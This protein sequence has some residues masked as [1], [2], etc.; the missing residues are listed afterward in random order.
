MK[1]HI[2]YRSYLKDR[3]VGTL[4]PFST[5][6][7]PWRDNRPNVSCIL[8]D[9][10]TCHRDRNGRYKYYRIDDV[11]G[12]TDIEFHGGIVVTHSAGCILIGEGFTPEFNLWR[13]DD[14]LSNFVEYMGEESF[15]LDIRVYQPCTKL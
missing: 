10:Y 4:G 8:P 9:V 14:T 1:T 3:T 2:L 7:R 12:R 15:N 6:E 11:V 5:L 13:N